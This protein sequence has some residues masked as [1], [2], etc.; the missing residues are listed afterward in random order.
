MPRNAEFL[1]VAC[2][3]SSHPARHM[4]PYTDHLDR[5]DLYILHPPNKQAVAPQQPLSFEADLIIRHSPYRLHSRQ[6]LDAAPQLTCK[7]FLTV[8]VNNT[9]RWRRQAA[10]VLA[11]VILIFTVLILIMLAAVR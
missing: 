5:F 11:G 10:T 9:I 8:S 3:A 7:V 2:I 4:G 6:D 1:Y